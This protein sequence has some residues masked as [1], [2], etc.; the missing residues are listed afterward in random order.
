MKQS[1]WIVKNSE[2]PV[3][4]ATQND[5][6]KI[7]TYNIGYASGEKNNWGSVCTKEEIQNNLDN[8]ANLIIKGQYDF[9]FLQEV[10]F[11][12][13]RSHF[14]NQFDYLLK[15][16]AY[17]FGAAHTLWDRRHVP[18][19]YWPLKKQFGKVVSGQALLSRFQ[20][21]QQEIFNLPQPKRAPWFLYFYP[22]RC[23]QQIS[24]ATHDQNTP[25]F[26]WNIHLEAYHHASR[27]KQAQVLAKLVQSN[28]QAMQIVA[29]DFNDPCKEPGNF[30]PH[31]EDAF[32][33][34][35]RE[36]G[37]ESEDEWPDHYLTFS[38]WEPFEQL[39]H[40]VFSKHFATQSVAV[41]GERASDHL[42][43]GVSL[44]N[45]IVSKIP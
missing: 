17:P 27:N 22:R 19:P 38:S 32:S 9:V 18:W 40:V 29:G 41:V 4:D 21:D 20:I 16:T 36:S 23:A 26:L 5:T 39:D 14:I 12:S 8:I 44:L 25:L 37:F 13:K 45:H 11:N 10:D 31:L 1:Q 28:K 34:F 2:A 7:L 43:L 42:G 15:Q 35:K 30:D 24:I 3:F 33:L 6:I